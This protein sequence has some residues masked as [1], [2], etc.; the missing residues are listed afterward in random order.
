MVKF[1]LKNENQNEMMKTTEK[2]SLSKE[3][4]NPETTN[5]RSNYLLNYYYDSKELYNL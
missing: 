5:P 3:P 4:S 1:K 2:K